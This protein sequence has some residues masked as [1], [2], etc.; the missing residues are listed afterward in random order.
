MTAQWPTASPARKR[1]RPIDLI[2]AAPWLLVAVLVHVGVFLTLWVW[3]PQVGPTPEPIYPVA[4]EPVENPY[5]KPAPWQGPP[6]PPGPAK[7]ID[8]SPPPVLRAPDP[9]PEPGPDHVASGDEP[10]SSAALST[11]VALADRKGPYANRTGSGRGA[12]LA[13]YGGSAETESAVHAGLLWLAAHQRRDGAWDRRFFN[14]QCPELDRCDQ[15]AVSARHLDAGPGVTGLALLAF[16]GAGHTHEQ[17]EFQSNVTLGLHYLLLGQLANGSFAT[18]DSLEMY[19]HSIAT[20]AMAE[21]YAMTGDLSLKRPLAAAAKHLASSQQ[22]GGGWDY[23]SDTSTGRSDMS[24]T[25]WVVMALKSLTAGG[26]RIPDS[27]LLGIVDFVVRATRYEGHVSYAHTSQGEVVDNAA[28]S[29][30]RRYGPGT[31]AIGAFVQ[32]LLGWRPGAP[33]LSKQTEL[34][35][36]EPPDLKAFHG[37]D[38][39]GLHS[40]Y[41]WYYGTL[42]MFNQGG[43]AWATWNER[44][45]EALLTSQDRSVDHRGVKGHSWGSWPAYGP[46]WGRWGRTGG[47][48]YSTALSV[49]MLESYYRYTP[50]FLSSPGLITEGALR[51]GLADPTTAS[52]TSLVIAATNLTAK[53]GEPVLADLLS[54]GDARERLRAAIGLAQHGSPLGRETLQDALPRSTTREREVIE[55]TLRQIEAVHLPK[56]YGAVIRVDS[57]HGV[58]VFETKGLAVYYGQSLLIRRDD[59]TIAL[60]RVTR[61]LSE[62]ALAAAELVQ[63]GRGEPAV[64]VGDEV[65]TQGKQVKRRNVGNG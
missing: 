22:V 20:I 33:V 26:V 62:H 37:G 3:G 48:I 64:Q 43:G 59:K 35:L 34:M 24:V 19:N 18:V 29:S 49:M 7:T 63:T 12:A 31:T 51:A 61:R 2:D 16:L 36:A 44:I 65:V 6:T 41:Y 25:G 60:A 28:D 5:E 46:G 52:R 21:A 42:A 14:R 40:E 10:T 23:S 57:E 53:I 27:T 11:G 39:S 13:Q 54:V 8:T 15:T 45:K 9:T 1:R 47:R 56:R 38:P 58:V 50:A 32:Q 4:L 17:G 30:T 55:E